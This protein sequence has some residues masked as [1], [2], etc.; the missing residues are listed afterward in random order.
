MATSTIDDLHRR[1]GALEAENT[2][3]RAGVAPASLAP[4]PPTSVPRRRSR[5]WGRTLTATVLIVVGT[6]LAP[7]ALVSAWANVQ[8]TDTER[9]V[10]SYAVLA[11]DP[12]VQS[13]VT[14]QVVDVIGEQVD[15]P[16]LTADVIDGV[17]ELGTGPAA[18][19]ALELLKGPAAQGLQSLVATMVER[20][21]ESEAFANVWTSALRISHSQV[22]SAL[23]NDPEA[24]IAL[25]A[26]GSIG[27]QLAPIVDA[28]KD[29][30]VDQGIGFATSIPAVDRTITVAQ[31][32]SL[33]T[34]QLGYQ[35]V[36]AAG[37]WLPWISILLLAAGVLAARR[38]STAGITASLS[39]GL[40]MVI[41]LAGLAVGRVFFDTAMRANGI[42]A[43]AGGS[44]YER[45]A[46]PLRDT[47]V[48]V[49]VLALVTAAVIWFAGPFEVPRRLRGAVHGGAAT[50]RASLERRGL[51]SGR[52]GAWLHSRRTLLRALIALG[53]AA[54]VL[55]VRPLTTTLILWTLA[56]ALL[57][58]LI[59]DVVERPPTDEVEPAEEIETSDEI[60]SEDEVEPASADDDATVPADAAETGGHPS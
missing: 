37:L 38:R 58:V 56:L 7:V 1:L 13:A 39:L 27:I 51:S 3:L 18:T 30:L 16:T 26:D 14:D 6:V 33:S 5:T 43:D 4:V 35:L 52:V 2:A 9:F 40:V 48:A 32:D 15:I 57:A 23:Q 50:V 28:A 45:V 41:V 42:D 47:A 54:V 8:L 17:I 46:G 44:I 59:L 60:E 53:S 36:V 31:L 11:S 20:F 19:R 49:L 24:A 55:L 25:G 34:V 12:A 10:A 21:V 29:A 22:V